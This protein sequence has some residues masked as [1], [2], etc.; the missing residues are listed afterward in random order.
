MVVNYLYLHLPPNIFINILGVISII[1]IIKDFIYTI[2][3]A[4]DNCTGIKK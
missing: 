3:K 1:L 2:P 4:K